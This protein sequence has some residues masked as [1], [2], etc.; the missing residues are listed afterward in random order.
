M[1]YEEKAL[2]KTTAWFITCIVVAFI[3]G[4]SWWGVNYRYG[5]ETTRKAIENGYCEVYEPVRG[6]YYWTKCPVVPPATPQK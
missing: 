4:I 5:Q 3:V 2:D 1:A 6:S